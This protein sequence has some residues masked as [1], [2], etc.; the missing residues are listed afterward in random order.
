MSLEMIASSS[1]FP[2]TLG[3]TSPA[4]SAFF[5]AVQSCSA[6]SRISTVRWHSVARCSGYAFILPAGIVQT[7]STRS[8]LSHIASLTSADSAAQK[9]SI[10]R[11][12][13]FSTPAE[14]PA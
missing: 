1:A 11:F 6:S 14:P 2:R 13:A 5:G 12:G 3:K 4:N 7:S 8:I 10:F 9:D